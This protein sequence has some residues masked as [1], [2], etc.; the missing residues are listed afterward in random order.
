MRL[1]VTL[2]IILSLYSCD[3]MDDRL[4]VL[5]NTKENLIVKIC[6][7]ENEK[8]YDTW[9]GTRPLLREKENEIYILGSW[10][11][12]FKE[13]QA[14]N[15][16]VI[17][18]DQYQLFLDSEPDRNK[19]LSDSLLQLGD[20]FYKVYSYEELELRDWKIKYPEDYFESGFPAEVER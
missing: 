17:I 16:Y 13:R 18:F 19:I 14:K 2:L 10:E 8:L 20:Y 3:P 12:E 6:L 15:M 4:V 11:S 9:A 1:V 5:N 7:I